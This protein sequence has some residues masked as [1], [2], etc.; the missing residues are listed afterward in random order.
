LTLDQHRRGVNGEA[1]VLRWLCQLRDDELIKDFFKPDWVVIPADH[2]KNVIYSAAIF[3]EG[4]SQEHF[5]SPPFDGHGLPVRQ[6]EN[7]HAVLHGGGPPT[8]LLVIEGGI[9]YHQ[10]LH[11][12]ERGRKFETNG[13]EPR[14]IYPLESFQRGIRGWPL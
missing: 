12:L 3:V 1:L 7:Y 14:R 10:Y 8:L 2:A 6:A 9:V 4:K 5:E 11:V 13:V